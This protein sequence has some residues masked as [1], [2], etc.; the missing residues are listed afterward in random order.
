MM[1][2]NAI[3]NE[4]AESV[5]SSRPNG[6]LAEWQGDLDLHVRQLTGS[7]KPGFTPKH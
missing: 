3:Q 5:I 4:T 7:V 6:Y 1:S 2:M